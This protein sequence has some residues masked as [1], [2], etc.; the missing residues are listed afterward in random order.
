DDDAMED[1]A[2]AAEL[3]LDLGAAHADVPRAQRREAIGAVRARVLLVA[4]AYQGR[5]EQPHDQGE[6]L[7]ARD[8]GQSKVGRDTAADGRQ[9]LAEG[10]HA[11]E[12]VGVA[13]AHPVR[14]VDVL[15][16]PA[17]VASGRLHV[18]VVLR[19]YPHI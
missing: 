6:H 3:E 7:L 15:L 19:A 16:A 14:V 10:P 18:A 5:I 12:L 13:H 8:A 9:R 2:L 4:H 11:G 17:R 1:P